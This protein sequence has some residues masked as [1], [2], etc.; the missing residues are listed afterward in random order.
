MNYTYIVECADGTYYTGWTNDP[1]KRLRAHNEGKGAKYTKNRR[2]VRFVYLES[3][4]DRIDAMRR[5]FAIKQLTRQEKEC[6]VQSEENC[7]ADWKKMQ[8]E[9]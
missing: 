2:P 1:E 7:L 9:E 8:P 4:E 5:E 6:L 3:H